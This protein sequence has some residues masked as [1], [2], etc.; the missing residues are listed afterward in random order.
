MNVENGM[1]AELTKLTAHGRWTGTASELLAA[2]Q[3]TGTPERLSRELSRLA[4]DLAAAGIRVERRRQAGTGKRL[5]IIERMGCD[6]NVTVECDANPAT[7]TGCDSNRE[8]VTVGCDSKPS[9]VTATRDQGADSTWA[10][11]TVDPGYVL[12]WRPCEKHHKGWC[13]AFWPGKAINARA[14]T[15]CPLVDPN[16]GYKW[17]GTN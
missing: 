1:I 9:H 2:L 16:Y 13:L 7:V 12:D 15:A 11:L 6:G 3:H 8:G 4:S 17:P 14:L 5:W 10:M